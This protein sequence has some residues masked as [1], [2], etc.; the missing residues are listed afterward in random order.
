MVGEL[1]IGSTAV[2]LIKVVELPKTSGALKL[3]CDGK[4]SL[5]NRSEDGVSAVVESITACW[6]AGVA[7][8]DGW[9]DTVPELQQ[10]GH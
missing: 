1:V 6:E 4:A 7:T 8:A 10:L 5:T 2:G 3:G 9:V